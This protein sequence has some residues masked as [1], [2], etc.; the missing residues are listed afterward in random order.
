MD[1][2]AQ[3]SNMMN[4]VNAINSQGREIVNEKKEDQ[5]EKLNEYKKTLE[6]TTEGIGGGILHDVGINLIKKGF[7]A[8]KDKIPV[9]VDELEKMV[10]DYKD[11]GA[12]KMF[13]GMTKRGYSKAKTK[14]FG[15]AEDGEEG[16]NAVKKVFGKLFQTAKSQ[17]PSTIGN[18]ADTI[19]GAGGGAG[20]G[21]GAD[22]PDVSADAK[23]DFLDGQAEKNI[24]FKSIDNQKDLNAGITSLDERFNKLPKENQDAFTDA[25]VKNPAVKSNDEI[26]Q[27]PKG[28]PEKLEAKVSQQTARQEVLENEEKK[29]FDKASSQIPDEASIASKAKTTLSRLNPLQ[30]VDEE[31]E[32]SAQTGKGFFQKLLNAGKSKATDAADDVIGDLDSASLQQ[33]KKLSGKVLQGLGKDLEDGEEGG[34]FGLLDGVDKIGQAA[35]LGSQFFKKGETGK[36]REDLLG[37]TA[38]Q[39][40]IDNVKDKGTEVLSDS[41]A[42]DIPDE[43]KLATSVVKDGVESDVKATAEKAGTRLLETDAELGGPE[44][45]IGDVVSGIV[46]L[47]TLLGG[48]F[49]AK[50]KHAPPVAAYVPINATFQSGA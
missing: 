35:T 43:T 33:P 34:G 22:I 36:Q 30:D 37:S 13:Q 16:E 3:Y 23:Q 25:L 46:G 9:P 5:Q 31:E 38:K 17:V 19:A 27:L 26:R 29:V 50:K 41:L 48:I 24:D 11:G 47:G 32:D 8:I 49:G 21:A 39:T 18:A 20:A 4:Q 15:D 10:A 42:D 40:I 28:S 44:D 45:P 2:Y 6:M 1:D 12:K 14:L 7:A